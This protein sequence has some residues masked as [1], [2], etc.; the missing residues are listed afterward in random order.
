MKKIKQQAKLPTKK[1]YAKKYYCILHTAD[2][3]HTVSTTA[4]HTLTVV[5]QAVIGIL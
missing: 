3:A 1:Y 2:T 4:Q 5:K